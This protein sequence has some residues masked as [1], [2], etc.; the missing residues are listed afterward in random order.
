[1]DKRMQISALMNRRQIVHGT[2]YF[3]ELIDRTNPENHRVYLLGSKDPFDE[4]HERYGGT[5]DEVIQRIR[6]DPIDEGSALSQKCSFGDMLNAARNLPEISLNE[7]RR[8]VLTGSTRHTSYMWP[9]YS[10]AIV[11]TFRRM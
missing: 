8:A 10:C 11:Y 5:F 9:D 6:E 1:M 4:K 3:I 2:L 7:F